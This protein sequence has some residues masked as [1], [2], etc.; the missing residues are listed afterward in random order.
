MPD[1]REEEPFTRLIRSKPPYSSLEPGGR[2]T[3]QYDNIKLDQDMVW[4]SR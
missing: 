3:V 4:K 2:V 1:P